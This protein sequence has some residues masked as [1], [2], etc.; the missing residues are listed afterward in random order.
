MIVGFLSADL[1]RWDQLLRERGA[2]PSCI[3]LP[4]FEDERPLRGAAGLCDWRLGGRISRLLGARIGSQRDDRGESIKLSGSFGEKLLLPTGPR[5]PFGRLVLLG[6][7]SS[8]LFDEARAQT[9][10]RELLKTLHALAEKHE[11]G[12]T[13][14][15]IVP[16]GRSTGAL[17]SRR[18][19]E[20]LLEE[21]EASPKS[22][23]NMRITV[24][25]SVAGQKEAAELARRFAVVSS[26]HPSSADA[27]S[28]DVG[29]GSPV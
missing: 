16:P 28:G 5:L 15:A 8:K 10:S 29:D 14:L 2:W 7:G 17:S 19:L 11:D 12:R 22:S 24:I 23:S 13:H 18:A 21:A 9:A 26:G 4:F 6:L 1:S 25:E 20:I 27:R 3:G